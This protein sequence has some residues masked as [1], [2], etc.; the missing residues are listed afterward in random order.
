[1]V[2]LK[3]QHTKILIDDSGGTPRDV[4]AD[5]DSID[6]P[7]DFEEIDVTGFTETVVNEMPGML[8]APITLAGTFNAAATTGLYTVL[9]GIKGVYSAHTVTIQI[10]QNDN[11]AHLSSTWRY[12]ESSMEK[13][14]RP[15]VTDRR[16]VV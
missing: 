7:Q 2:K 16:E 9:N 5:L 8:T 15:C 6:I 3:A 11:T 13:V 4:S 14:P 10:G 1:M 12:C